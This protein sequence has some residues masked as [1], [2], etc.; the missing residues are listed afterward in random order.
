MTPVGALLVLCSAHRFRLSLDARP[1]QVAIRCLGS[2]LQWGFPRPRWR[3]R[4]GRA[5]W[6]V[7]S[8]RFPRRTLRRVDRTVS[9]RLVRTAQLVDQFAHRTPSGSAVSIQPK[10]PPERSVSAGAKRRTRVNGPLDNAAPVDRRAR[11]MPRPTSSP[12]V[13]GHPPPAP[14]AEATAPLRAEAS[15]PPQWLRPGGERRPRDEHAAVL[16]LCRRGRP[17]VPHAVAPC[18]GLRASLG[19]GARRGTRRPP[20]AGPG[21]V[22]EQRRLLVNSVSEWLQ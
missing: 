17:G 13:P 1:P 15:A 18:P 6:E 2:R 8:H 16:V 5:S 14:R 11:C 22:T 9:D 20:H 21:A 19:R 12:V 3:R 7:L 4:R 10:P